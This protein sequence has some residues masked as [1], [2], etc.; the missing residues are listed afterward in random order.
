MEG[1]KGEKGEVD[2]EYIEEIKDGE[3]RDR[4]L[5]IMRDCLGVGMVEGKVEGGM[6]GEI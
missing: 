3:D 1:I 5:G 4:K 2:G 6:L